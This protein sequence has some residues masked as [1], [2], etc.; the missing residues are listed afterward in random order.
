LSRGSTAAALSY[1]SLFGDAVRLIC[2]LIGSPLFPAFLCSLLLRYG[3]R[4]QRHKCQNRRA[5]DNRDL[6]FHFVVSIKRP[7]QFSLERARAPSLNCNVS[8]LRKHS[9]AS[10]RLRIRLVQSPN[11]IGDLNLEFLIR[12]EFP[13][14]ARKFSLNV[15]VVAD[16]KSNTKKVTSGLTQRPSY[17][18]GFY[19]KGW[20]QRIDL[21]L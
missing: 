3:V 12:V 18:N 4:R 11:K 5:H 19:M 7:E 16:P 20:S 10:T 9:E 14:A 17:Q 1:I 13:N 15:P 2:G 21:P 8:S 6:P